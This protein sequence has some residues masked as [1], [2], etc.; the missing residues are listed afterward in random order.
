MKAFLLQPWSKFVHPDPM[1]CPPACA[2]PAMIN[3]TG[4]TPARWRPAPHDAVSVCGAAVDGSVL[5]FVRRPA[6]E[7]LFF[8]SGVDGLAAG[9]ISLLHRDESPP[10]RGGPS[11]WSQACGGETRRMVAQREAFSV[12]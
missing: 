5:S 11:R 12:R 10:P 2:T 4:A 7:A 6:T 3:P 9:F 8:L 1:E